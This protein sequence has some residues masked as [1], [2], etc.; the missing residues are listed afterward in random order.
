MPLDEFIIYNY[1]LSNICY[2]LGV[3]NS[4]HNENNLPLYFSFI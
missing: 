4:K 3:R 2:I 1:Q